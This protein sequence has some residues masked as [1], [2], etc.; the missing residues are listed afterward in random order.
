[1]TNLDTVL[2]SRN[3]TL[4]TKVHIWSV[5]LL[6]RV[7]LFLTTWTAAR[8]A[9]VSITNSLNLLKF[10][11]IESMMPSKHLI[12]CHPLRLLSSVFPTIRVFSNELALC[13]R[14]PKYWTSALASILPKYIQDLFPLRSTGLIL[15]SK[16]LSS[17]LQ[18]HSSKTSI[19]WCSTFFM[20]QLL[21]P[22]TTTG[23]ARALT[24]WT[25]V[26]KV[27]SLFFNMLSRLIIVLFQ[28]A[29]VFPYT[30][31][32]SFP[33]VMYGYESWT[34]KNAENHRIDGSELW[35]WRRLLSVP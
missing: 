9:S 35:C 23:K 30:Q 8:Q 16:G 1:M 10:I 7:W 29:S 17:L 15:Q 19:L 25:F 18:H 21:H 32:Y 11:S 34:I 27:I 33:V 28:R 3:I 6:S 12:F 2:K 5:Q 31:S 13:I 14:W 4:P 26:S 20:F 22:Y 24:R